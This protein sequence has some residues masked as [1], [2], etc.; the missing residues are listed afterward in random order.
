MKEYLIKIKDLIKKAISFRGINPHRH[1]KNVLY[2]FSAVV[3]IIVVFSFF[4]LFKIKNQQIFQVETPIIEQT[5]IINESLFNKVHES[6]ENKLIK[7][8]EVISG[9]ILYKDPSL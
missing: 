8:K 1:W 4:L 7:Q 3:I 6:F 5:N 2:F 9:A